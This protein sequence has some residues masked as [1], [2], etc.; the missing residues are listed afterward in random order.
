MRL[1]AILTGRTGEVSP[2]FCLDKLQKPSEPDIDR[3][4]AALGAQTCMNEVEKS[5]TSLNGSALAQTLSLGRSAR[6]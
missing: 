3:T 6:T 2:F 5:A 4:I 1:A